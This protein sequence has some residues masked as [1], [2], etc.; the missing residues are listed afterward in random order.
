M[1]Q[2]ELTDI[3]VSSYADC[4]G[5]ELVARVDAPDIGLEAYIGIHDTH[6]GPALGGCRMHPYAGAEDAIKD[7][8][9]LSR[10][11]SYKAALAGLPLGGGKSVIIGD[12]QAPGK[13]DKLEAMGK[14]IAA[15]QGT[16]ITAEDV[17]MRERDMARIHQQTAY[18]T[19]LPQS[20]AGRHVGGNPAPVTAYGVYCAIQAAVRSRY[21]HSSLQGLRV[22]VQGVGAVGTALC[23]LLR[24]AG[25]E[26]IITDS[27]IV[28]AKEL[29]RTYP[30]MT[31]VNQDRI[32]SVEA[33]IFAPCA[34]GA[35]L[36]DATI[37]LLQTPIVAGAANNQLARDE[38]DRM[39]A[40]R[41]I[42][43][44]P[45]Y[46]A[47]AGG[48]ICVAYEYFART[49]QQPF[50]TPISYN[51]MMAHV[52]GIGTTLEDIFRQASDLRQPTGQIADKRARAI[53]RAPYGQ[54]SVGK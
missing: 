47:N 4:D 37:P 7:V 14:A 51:S 13:A 20:E 41:G 25:A 39:L 5:H 46:I 50:A 18:V 33:D 10:G 2:I 21:Q 34:M 45:D 29:Q 43:Y 30:D 38:H 16:Y 23:I 27:D 24:D 28:R 22:A 19:G 53:F 6:L 32:F 54:Q 36:D 35:V 44:A 49:G 12:P 48:L 17:G 40:D 26:L 31:I 52:A 1:T 8:L 11:M 9:R 15:L 3:D 42:V